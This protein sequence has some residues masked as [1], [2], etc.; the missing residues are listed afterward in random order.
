MR[1]GMASVFLMASL[2]VACSSFSE[3]TQG[4]NNVNEAA[5][6]TQEVTSQP[7]T[8]ATDNAT[9]SASNTTL[10][11]PVRCCVNQAFYTCD[12]AA[13][14][15]EC[16]GEPMDMV[17]CMQNCPFADSSCED[18]CVNRYGPNPS[19][20]ARDASRDAECR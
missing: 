6:T 11:E 14:A 20:C 7:V 17:S 12:T 5:Q 3:F 4:I 16:I 9:D 2:M 18:S 13:A 1:S 10:D 15:S 8:H 19:P